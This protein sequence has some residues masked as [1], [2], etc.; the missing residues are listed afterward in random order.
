MTKA[1]LHKKP[2][3][4][5]LEGGKIKILPQVGSG[6]IWIK[7]NNRQWNWMIEMKNTPS[8]QWLKYKGVV[9]VGVIKN[10]AESKW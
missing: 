2:I 7:Q 6:Y 1:D 8:D 9:N 5:M 10:K 3:S 4:P